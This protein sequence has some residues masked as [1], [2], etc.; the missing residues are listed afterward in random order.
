MIAQKQSRIDKK[1]KLSKDFFHTFSY[2]SFRVI[3]STPALVDSVTVWFPDIY[4]YVAATQTNFSYLTILTIV[5]FSTNWLSRDLQ[6]ASH[7]R[8]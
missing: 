4:L 1:R 5:V 8:N 7:C 2:L 3:P 6:R